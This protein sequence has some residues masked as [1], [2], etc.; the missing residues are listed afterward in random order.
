MPDKNGA[1][2]LTGLTLDGGWTVEAIDE[3]PEGAT[4]GFF[5]VGYLVKDANGRTGYLKAL[6][7]SL[8]ASGGTE[9]LQAAIEAFNF[10]T[11]KGLKLHVRDFNTERP[12][13]VQIGFENVNRYEGRKIK[14]KVE[15]VGEI[16]LGG[17]KAERAYL[18]AKKIRIV[19]DDQ[20]MRRVIVRSASAMS[21]DGRRHGHSSLPLPPSLSG[22]GEADMMEETFG[23]SSALTMAS[24]KRR[25]VTSAPGPAALRASLRRMSVIG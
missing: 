4:G 21:L 22:T 20:N 11:V 13:P 19:I 7:F 6:D 14:T 17:F 10:E 9:A 1:A 5:S 12:F 3:R 2:L 16:S 25:T 24:R 18:D 15:V 23:R 8:V